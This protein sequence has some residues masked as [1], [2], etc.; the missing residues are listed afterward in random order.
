MRA[1]TGRED[2]NPAWVIGYAEYGGERLA[3][4]DHV[5][6]Q[7]VLPLPLH[8]RYSVSTLNE[9]VRE[10]SQPC[11]R[12]GRDT[13]LFYS[14]VRSAAIAAFEAEEQRL[15]GRAVSDAS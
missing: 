14:N 2:R 3:L 10:E 1:T 8:Y 13:D 11:L 5:A 6:A 12:L 15:L 7:C 9:A 4:I